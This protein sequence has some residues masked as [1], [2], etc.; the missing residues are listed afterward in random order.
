MRW[1][2]KM[3]LHVGLQSVQLVDE[4][5]TSLKMMTMLSG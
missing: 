4:D 3:D 5:C 2:V 1:M